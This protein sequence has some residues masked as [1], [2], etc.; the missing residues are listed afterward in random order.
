MIFFICSWVQF[1]C[2]FVLFWFGLVFLWGFSRQGLSVAL[3]PVLKLALV[4]KD[5]LELREIHLSC[6]PS[7]GI[8]G[9]HSNLLS[10]FGSMFMGGIGL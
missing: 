9:V 7:A 4:D 8:K 10:I 5:G 3:E 2:F 6:L 1:A